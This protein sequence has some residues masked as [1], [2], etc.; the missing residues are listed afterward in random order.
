MLIVCCRFEIVRELFFCKQLNNSVKQGSLH[1]AALH[2][3][4]VEMTERMLSSASTDTAAS[5]AATYTA[6]ATSNAATA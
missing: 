3:A 4:S 2:Y 6:T 5:A 1:F